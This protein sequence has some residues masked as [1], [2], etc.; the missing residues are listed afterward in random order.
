MNRWL[1][2]LSLL[3]AAL[4]LAA[5][6]ALAQ[7]NLSWTDCGAAG[8]ADMTFAC[9]TNTGAPFVLVCSFP[10]INSPTA[11]ALTGVLDFIQV[12]A[13][14]DA[15]WQMDGSAF[16]GACRSSA[17]TYNADFTAGPFTCTDYWGGVGTAVGGVV[18]NGAGR[19]PNT[20]RFKI[21][22]GS[23]GTEMPMTDA[24]GELYAFKISILRSKTVGTGLCAGCSDPGCFV[25]NLIRVETTNNAN[26]VD[27]TGPA[28]GGRDQVTWQGAGASC[29]TVPAKN[30]TWGQVKALYH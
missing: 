27:L 14:Q 24:D 6:T 10:A 4:A 29:A 3:T 20:N 12:N 16:P 1:L 2:R 26:D 28:P 19:G 7:V 11:V 5:S 22:V 9:N 13:A 8:A 18:F 21:T 25:L 23:P 30:R 15:W 17:V